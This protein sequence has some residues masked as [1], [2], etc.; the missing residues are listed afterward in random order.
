[1]AVAFGHFAF[2]NERRDVIPLSFVLA[3]D[4][5]FVLSGFVIAHSLFQAPDRNDWISR[6]PVRRFFRIYPLYITAALLAAFVTQPLRGVNVFADRLPNI[7]SWLTLLQ[8]SGVGRMDADV[9]GSTPMGIGWALSVETWFCVLFFAIVATFRS[10]LRLIVVLAVCSLLSLQLLTTYSPNFMD[11][12]YWKLGPI[13]FGL[14][15][16]IAGFSAGVITYL[17]FLRIRINGHHTLWE[18]IA[19]AIAA[20]LYGH[21][22]YGRGAEF[23]APIVAAVVVFVF[24]HGEG[25]WSKLL[26]L[27]P[28][29][30][31]GRWSF[32]VYIAHPLLIDILAAS[33]RSFSMATL[34]VY[35]SAVVVLAWLLHNMVERPG[36]R[37]GARIL[38][39]N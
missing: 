12:H 6:F 10:R 36:M 16:G 38:S 29:R 39:N 1:M 26:L 25:W 35:L 20:A 5:F 7:L 14:L 11:V 37:L 24:A 19:V 34:T 18:T 8:M 13:H 4:F 32:G 31:L 3:V 22:G 17:A 21:I 2:W 30:A 28:F 9:I 33:G 27:P 15:R 23:F